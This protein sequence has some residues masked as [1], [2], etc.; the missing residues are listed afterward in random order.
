VDAGL[1]RTFREVARLGSFSA[2]A[3]SLG[4]TQSA[5]SRQVL[6]LE[7]EFGAVLFDRL[8]RGARLTA[9]GRCLLPHAE[10]VTGRIAAAHADLRAL[11]DLVG[12]RLRAGAFPTAAAALVPH[13]AAAFRA[14]HPAVAL[15]LGEG[16]SAELAARLRAG[17]LDLAVVAPAGLPDGVDL[18]H[19]L[20]DPMLVAMHPAHPLSGRPQVRLAELAEEG[21][22]AGSDRPEETLIGAAARA[23]FQPV[24]SHVIGEWVAKQGLVAAG[25]GI[26]LIPSLAASAVRPDIAVVPLHPDDSQPRPVFLATPA[27]ITPPP[28]AEAFTSLLRDAA[29][30]LRLGTAGQRKC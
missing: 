10:A 30:S 19:L 26:T 20:D 28:A 13:A 7:H 16:L 8:P 29:R 4:Y 14:A 25:L 24:I 11:R 27:G 9:E 12:G 22:I 17:D 21:W 18:S 15:S 23:G 6:V 1:L 3:D 2:A 5:V